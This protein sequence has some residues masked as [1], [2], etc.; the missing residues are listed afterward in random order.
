MNLPPYLSP[1]QRSQGP[2]Q[3]VPKSKASLWLLPMIGNFLGTY[4]GPF[5]YMYFC[6]SKWVLKKTLQP[7]GSWQYLIK[8]HYRRPDK[9]SSNGI[10]C[11]HRS[12]VFQGSFFDFDSGCTFLDIPACDMGNLKST[13][14]HYHGSVG[15]RSQ[16]TFEASLTKFLLVVI[17]KKRNTWPDF[18]WDLERFSDTFQRLP[19]QKEANV[20]CSTEL[21]RKK[22][23]AKDSA[24]K[25]VHENSHQQCRLNTSN[26]ASPE[27]C[28]FLLQVQ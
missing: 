22:Q 24:L 27:T 25:E 20:C 16:Q 15:W 4:R 10:G 19:K 6:V 9:P 26:R 23:L 1:K 5:L 17:F 2:K 12:C 14:R 13:C 8:F 3:S 7:F 21:L 28:F 11:V 18:C